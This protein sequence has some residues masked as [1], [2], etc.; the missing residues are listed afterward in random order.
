[1]K[2]LL[3]IVDACGCN[4]SHKARKFKKICMEKNLY[5]LSIYVN[6]NLPVTYLYIVPLII[7]KQYF[8]RL[9]TKI[10]KITIRFMKT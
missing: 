2:I 10:T 3:L 7:K 6:N 5:L 4:A 8:K 9:L 1:M